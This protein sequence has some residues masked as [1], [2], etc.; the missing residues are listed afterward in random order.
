MSSRV[1]PPLVEVFLLVEQPRQRLSHWSQ[2][3]AP[4]DGVGA[5]PVATVDAYYDPT[6]NQ[7]IFGLRYDELAL[8]PERLGRVVEVALLAEIGMIQPAELSEGDRRR[9]LGERLSKCT[10]H[11]G[12]QP[13]IVAALVELVRRVRSQKVV[14]SP[15]L[16]EPMP[17]VRPRASRQIPA[18]RPLSDGTTPPL[19]GVKR[20]RD[21][22]PAPRPVV[23]PPTRPLAQGSVRQPRGQGI[24]EAALDGVPEA[25]QKRVISEPIAA[26]ARDVAGTLPPRPVAPPRSSPNVIARA[27][28]H[29]ANTVLMPSEET[30]RILEAARR[31]RT[32][33]LAV[34]VP[35]DPTDPM[36][37]RFPATPAGSD[38]GRPERVRPV[39]PQGAESL[40]GEPTDEDGAAED[41][42]PSPTI[43]ARYLRSG[44]W[45]PVRVGSLS[46]KGASLL[47]GALPRIDDHVDIALAYGTQ[48]ALVRGIVPKVS[49]AEEVAASGASAFQVKFELDESSRH[50]LTV[51]LTAARAA[52]V[53]IKPPPSR[54]ARRYPVEWPV[55]LGTTR[56]AVRA[57]ALDVS[58]DGMFVKPLNALAL[59]ASITFTAVLDDG[60]P[61]ISG[62]SRVIRNVNEAAARA[63]GLAS[64][65][66]LSIV[67]MA[68]IDRQRWCAFLARIE[69]RT[70]KRVLIGASPARLAELQGG[71]VAAGY[72][73]TGGSDPGAL[74]QLA[75]AE[76]R[77]VDAALIDAA[78]LAGSSSPAWV[79]ELF[80][81]RK[82]PCVTVHGD[83]RRARIAIDRLLCVA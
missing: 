21:G 74:A 32:A 5:P 76:A 77:P 49:T 39:T 73:A 26:P 36:V 59:D 46:L 4:L 40:Y 62:R 37:E 41:T 18:A 29:R 9:F 20:T 2:A 12:D 23:A 63:A 35:I 11:V 14:A 25:E 79:E 65:Y 27:D 34:A 52:R 47:T 82:V 3:L 13:R 64:G 60:L 16:I 50:H 42:L 19:F 58:A 83:A 7:A 31:S 66:G 28:V 69:K 45:V 55:C 15:P 57:D 51:L 33:E 8:G 71:L 53:T 22:A 75:S 1:F 17:G 72:A 78:W 56:G 43:H 80:S 48:R 44:R 38:P 68:S 70:S 54:S 67:E 6:S 10:V 30:E 61:P 81:A 24:V